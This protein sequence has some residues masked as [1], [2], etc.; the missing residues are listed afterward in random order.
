M[1]PLRDPDVHVNGDDVV[2]VDATA[3]LP[4]AVAA[5]RQQNAHGLAPVLVAVSDGAL[6]AVKVSWGFDDWL[7]AGCTAAELRARLRLAV[8]TTTLGIAPVSSGPLVVDVDRYEVRAH[9]RLLDL[10]YKEFELLRALWSRPRFVWTRQRL[11]AEVWDYPEIAGGS[12]TVD[13]HVRR[14]R[15]KLGPEIASM[16]STVRGVGYKF[17]PNGHAPSV[18]GTREHL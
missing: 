13:V 6:A 14:L 8:E 11:L 4:G 12:R 2:V 15:A 10:T 3:D 9:G 16:I 1:A 5:C 18:D 7:L 17:E